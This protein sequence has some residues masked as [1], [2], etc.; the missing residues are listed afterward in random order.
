MGLPKSLI[1]KY[2]ISK[3]AWAVYR[4]TSKKSHSTSIKRHKQLNKKGRFMAKRKHKSSRKSSS[5]F[6]INTAGIVAPV[7]Y[8]A[9]RSKISNYLAPYTS[10]I[11]AGAISD[12]VG[13]YL[14]AMLAKK[15]LFKQKGVLRDALSA[16]QNI[17]LAMI[18]E[19]IASGQV[20]LGAL[21]SSS[22]SDSG[23]IF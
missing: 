22:T 19:A 15:F 3:K 6:G 8:G 12:E 11:P 2:G 21:G 5:M 7:L 16:G 20:N 23:N 14:A 17:E 1:K 9:V 13:M 10:K 18:G 4:G